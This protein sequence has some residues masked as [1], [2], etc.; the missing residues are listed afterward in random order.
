MGRKRKRKKKGGKA[1]PIGVILV[2]LCLYL[3]S[4]YGN[5]SGTAVYINQE[6]VAFSANTGEPFT[7]AQGRMQVPLRAVM[8]AYGCT[9]TWTGE[10]TTLEKGETTVQVPVGKTYLLVNGAKKSTDT[11]AMMQE[12]RTYLPIR[13]VLEA[14]GAKV[15]W[16][17]EKN[18]VIITESPEGLVTVHFIDVGQADAIFIDNREFE[19]LIDGGNNKDGTTVAEYLKD[20]VDG[21]LDMIIATH[22]DADHIGGLDDVIEAYSVSKIIDSGAGKKT[23][24]Y[25]EYWQA[26]QDEADCE[27][28]YDEDITFDLGHGASLKLIE[29]GD[30]FQDVNDSSVVAQLNYGEVSLLLTGDM[31]R[32]AELGSLSKF[33]KITVLKSGHHGSRTSS[34]QALLDILQPEYVVISAGKENTYGHPHRAVLERYFNGGATVYGTFRS[35]IIV[36]HTDGATVT[37]DTDDPVVLS[38]AGDS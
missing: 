20:Y 16:D 15:R 30:D 36:M 25:E 3:V 24:T 28:L 8:E 5:S 21:T 27:I 17:G 38:D 19:V 23:K 35:G 26:A 13:P 6:K 10:D 11:A 37:F 14:F 29:T 31:G 2:V 4:V 7:D 18:A 33:E 34:S 1:F 12:G 32:T 9:V 22:P